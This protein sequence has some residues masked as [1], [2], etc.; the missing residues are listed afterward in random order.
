MPVNHQETV[1]LRSYLRP[2]WRRKWLIVAITVLAAGGAYAIT[3]LHHSS[4]GPPRY[5]STTQVYIETA[6]PTSVVGP[7]AGAPQPPDS[8]QMSDAGYLFTGQTIT[9]AVY[10]ELHLPVGSAGTVTAAPNNSGSAFYD[11]TSILNITAT[12]SSP[13][14]AA[15]LANTYVS[16]Y[17]ASRSAAY[18][19]TASSD[20][21]ADQQELDGLP[22]TTA[23]AATRSNLQVEILS[24]RAQARNPQAEAYQVAT[25]TVPT[26]PISTGTPRSPVVYAAI[27]AAIALLL[28]VAI[29]FGLSMFDRRLLEVPAI[30]QSYGHDVLAILPHV[31]NA[32]PAD[33]GRAA[34]PPHL[35]EA[36]RALRVNLRLSGGGKRGPRT[37]LVTSA[38]PGEGKS[39]LARNLA[40]VCAEGGERV[41]LIDADLRRPSMTGLF[42]VDPESGLTQVLEG[43]VSPGHA[44]V[45]IISGEQQHASSNGASANGTPAGAF[46]APLKT[47]VTGSLDLLAHGEL[48]ENP[49]TLLASREMETLLTSARDLYDIIVIDSAPILAVTDTV[50]LLDRVDGVLL[51]ARVG[52]TTRDAAQRLSDTI[53]R[54]GGVKVLGVVANDVRDTFLDSGYGGM[55]S[56]RYGGYGYRDSARESKQPARAG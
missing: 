1:D 31:G 47:R 42:A 2:I 5:S 32:S 18:A 16:V 19:S 12:S 28:G 20:A 17:L 50:P 54:V 6:D 53:N 51:V 39:T 56:G 25:A 23:N 15:K 34:I 8:T 3:K 14:L 55:Y 40:L 37:L 29:A 13:A 44:V 22:N 4:S 33:H 35:V 27:A 9:S 10:K 36:L 11:G 46:D 21:R 24:L 38:M 45:Q 52:V 48:L 49:V 41:L 43:D 30:E 7:N 26:S